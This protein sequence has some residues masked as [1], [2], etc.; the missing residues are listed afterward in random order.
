MKRKP[1]KKKEFDEMCKRYKKLKSL[2]PSEFTRLFEAH[3]L[4]NE[5]FEKLLDELIPSSTK[6]LKTNRKS[7]SKQIKPPSRGQ[8][9]DS[10][11]YP[12][13]R[14]LKYILN[15][16]NSVKDPYTLLDFVKSLWMFK[17]WG[18]QEEN[19]TDA[20]G[21]PKTRILISTSG[22][23]GNESI[24]EALKYNKSHLWQLF[25]EESRR[26]GHFKLLLSPRSRGQ[27]KRR[28]NPNQNK[29]I[30]L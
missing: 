12:T 8:A 9:L 18:W 20:I 19:T 23:S 17:D 26:G 5:S 10:E 1:D 6:M 2:T 29:E 21:T 30:K 11:G 28:A 4:L 24:V 3:L 22:W 25:W 7:P 13:K 27:R 14:A 16:P 15:Y